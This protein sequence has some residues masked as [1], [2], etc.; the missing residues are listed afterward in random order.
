M[1]LK[2]RR[3]A[4]ESKSLARRAGFEHLEHKAL[5]V[6]RWVNAHKI[7][8]VLVGPVAHAAR[9][10]RLARGTV[11]IVPAPYG[12]NY[13]R[14]ARALGAEHAILRS[15][16]GSVD[17][18]DAVAVKL[19]G[20]KLARGRRWMLRFGEHDLDVEVAGVS[21]VRYQE[22]L[23][24]ASRFELADGVSAEVA[25]LEDLEHFSHVRRTGS[26]PE[27][28]ITRNV[29]EEGS[30]SEDSG[31]AAAAAADDDDAS[32]GVD[33]SAAGAAASPGA[34]GS[35]AGAAASPAADE[36]DGAAEVR[37]GPARGS[38]G[39]ASG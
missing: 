3:P 20:E 19:S 14:L 31:A 25:S 32:P 13:E 33:G 16:R 7:D 27:F 23:Y 28:R 4:I 22:L 18:A 1:L 21:G 37:E 2:H 36:P 17:R 6:L 34:D 10:D 5:A 38:A 29:G 8:Y 12:R 24:E 30:G 9:G 35:A 15:D 26:A 11:A 39:D